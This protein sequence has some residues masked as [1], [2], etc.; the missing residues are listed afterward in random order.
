MALPPIQS[1]VA[2]GDKF[3]PPRGPKLTICGPQ[4]RTILPTARISITSRQRRL[5]CVLWTQ[6]WTLWRPEASKRRLSDAKLKIAAHRTAI[7]PFRG[8]N[9]EFAAHRAATLAF[10]TPIQSLVAEGD[11]IGAQG[12]L[13]CTISKKSK[14]GSFGA[15]IREVAIEDRNIGAQ[16]RLSQF[17]GA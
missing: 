10:S 11:I 2:K 6:N 5:N 13:I 17:I 12:R 8:L 3:G 7:W 15:L 16:G 1:L 4:G 9:F 14:L